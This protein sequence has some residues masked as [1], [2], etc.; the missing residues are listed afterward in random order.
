LNESFTAG[1]LARSVWH[2]FR[3]AWI[4]L[5]VFEALFKLLEARLFVPAIAVVLSG[6]QSQAGHIGDQVATIQKRATCISSRNR[7]NRCYNG[8]RIRKTLPWKCKKS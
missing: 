2:D 7:R 8:F 6:I 1:A 4:G 5:V 3:R